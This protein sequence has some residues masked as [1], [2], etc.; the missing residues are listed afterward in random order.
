MLTLE[1]I[2][3]VYLSEH[4]SGEAFHFS[5]Y[6]C[7]R[8]PLHLEASQKTPACHLPEPSCCG[9]LTDH[10]YACR[11][12]DEENFVIN[13]ERDDLGYWSDIHHAALS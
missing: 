12:T 10:E 3:T 5:L 13:W 8:H 9:F 7:M 11:L 6:V 4:S 1:G 2:H